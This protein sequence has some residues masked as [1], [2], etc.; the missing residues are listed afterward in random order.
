MSQVTF[1]PIT[2]AR[3]AAPILKWAGGKNGL[4]SQFAPHFPRRSDFKRY[5]EP[6]LG[7][8]AV[9]FYLQPEQ[10]FLFDLNA[11]LVEVYTVLR[12][13]V[14]GLINALKLHFNDRDY[15]YTTRAQDPSKL[16]PVERAS[17]FIF[18]NRTCYNGLYRVNR[19]GQFN[20]PY[21]DYKNPTICDDPGLRAASAALQSAML[22]VADF[23]IVLEYAQ[24]HDLVYFDPP[25]EPLSRTS[26]FT[27]YT[28]NGFTSADQYRLA[29]VFTT[30]D[31]RGCFL[32]LSNSNTTLIRELYRDFHLYEINARRAINSKGN[33]RGVIKELLVTNFVVSKPNV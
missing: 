10:S 14:E 20:V 21:G 30:L 2:N 13:D 3:S 12:D 8:A 24:I 11:Q 25:Y 7:G 33:G 22:E 32:M 29:E 9:F 19:Q 23:E 31:A 28:S 18:L 6:F 26:S 15:F 4:I 27:S 17:R 1:R 5:L 16:T